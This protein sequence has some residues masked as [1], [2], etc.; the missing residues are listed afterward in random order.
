M[1][2]PDARVVDGKVVV[3]VLEVDDVV[4][5]D[6][7]IESVEVVKVEVLLEEDVKAVVEVEVEEVEE[8]VG[9][10]EVE[11]AI[12]ETVDDV[13]VMEVVTGDEVLVDV[14]VV[15][16]AEVEVVTA[17]KASIAN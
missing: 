17:G 2:Q 14:V 13:V 4:G 3:L 10:A 16:F 7:G 12:V 15:G 11:V 9:V 5:E 1:V 8:V 6:M